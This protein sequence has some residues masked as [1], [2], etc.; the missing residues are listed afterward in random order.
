MKQTSSC[1]IAK[2][3]HAVSICHVSSLR[4]ADRTLQRVTF[5]QA[6]TGL[7]PMYSTVVFMTKMFYST[8]V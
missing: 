8:E 7:K 2:S 5:Y 1:K 6:P 3:L 4:Y